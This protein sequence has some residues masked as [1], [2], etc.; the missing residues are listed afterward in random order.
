MVPGQEA[1]GDDLGKSFRSSIQK[2][3]VVCTN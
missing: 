1:N 3:Y 2:L